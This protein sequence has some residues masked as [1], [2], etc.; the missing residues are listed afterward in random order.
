MSL[1]QSCLIEEFF[2]MSV[3]SNNNCNCYSPIRIFISQCVDLTFQFNQQQKQEED[4]RILAEALPLMVGKR[5]IWDF[6][7]SPRFLSFGFLGLGPGLHKWS[8]MMIMMKNWLGI[9]FQLELHNHK[10]RPRNHTNSV[11]LSKIMFLQHVNMKRQCFKS[12]AW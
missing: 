11:I 8:L 5:E 1:W 6:S 7:V 2:L 3:L 4:S 12:I 10:S 9:P